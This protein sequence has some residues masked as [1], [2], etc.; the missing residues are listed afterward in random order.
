MF[1]VDSSYVKFS[2]KNVDLKNYII[3]KDNYGNIRMMTK[4]GEKVYGFYGK[5]SP[6]KEIDE[7]NIS[8]NGKKI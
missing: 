2:V 3:K 8:I 4:R 7:I 1:K 6:K 5:I